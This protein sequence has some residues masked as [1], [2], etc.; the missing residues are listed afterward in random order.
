[1]FNMPS[2]CK[3]SPKVLPNV[4]QDQVNQI[5]W[6]S[7]TPKLVWVVDILLPL[8]CFCLLLPNIG[9]FLHCLSCTIFFPPSLFM[10]S[11]LNH[12]LCITTVHILS[13]T[14]LCIWSVLIAPDEDLGQGEQSTQDDAYR[15][16]G[17]DFSHGPIRIKIKIKRPKKLDFD[18][19]FLH[20]RELFGGSGSNYY[21]CIENKPK[22]VLKP[23]IKPLNVHSKQSL[24]TFKGNCVNFT[25][26]IF[27][28]TIDS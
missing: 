21:G 4:V 7:K 12:S 22:N 10:S 28:S 17:R 16:K 25:L 26:G 18:W 13:Q 14:W 2:V 23:Q 24:S 11:P 8:A 9:I 6:S 20:S 15:N 1:M 5:A 3:F 27:Y 19:I